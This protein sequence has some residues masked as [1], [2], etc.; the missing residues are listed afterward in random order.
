MSVYE[1]ASHGG[2]DQSETWSTE[3]LPPLA[4]PFASAALFVDP[5]LPAGVGEFFTEH[6]VTTPFAE[7]LS[8]YD[9]ADLEAEAFEA[10]RAEFEDDGFREAL[11]GLADEAAARHLGATGA[12]A[13]AGEAFPAATSE[14][15]HYMEAVAAQADRLLGELEAQ[16]GERPVDAVTAGEIDAVAGFAAHEAGGPLDAQEQFLKKLVGKVKKVVKGVGKLVKKGV[17]AVAKM[18]PLKKLFAFLKK[19][20][21]PLLARVLAKAIGRL[22]QDLQPIARTVAAKFRKKAPGA[23]PVAAPAD[24]AT[25]A[26][27][28]AAAE[29]TE[30][31]AAAPPAEEES[32]WSA[33]AL[34]DEFDARLAEAFLAPTEAAA[35]ELVDHVAA[36]AHRAVGSGPGPLAALDAGRQ[37]LARQL[38]EAEPGRPPLAEMEQFVPLVAASMKLLKL[39][40]K[41]IGRKR[42]VDAIAKPLAILIQGMVGQQAARK[43]SGHVADV[44]LRLLGL[45]AER[46]ADGMLGAEALV[47]TVEDTVREVLSMPAASLQN[48]L[49]LE[50]AVLE[51]FT[52]AAVRHLPA[53]VLRPDLAE[54]ETDGERGIWI[55]CPRAS[56]AHY[57][58]KKYSVVQPVHV[59]R[60]LARAVVFADGETLE[61]RLLEA[62]LPRFPVAAE[63]HFYELMDGAELGQL[64]AFELDG[65]AASYADGARE[66]EQLVPSRPLPIPHPKP[67][68]VVAVGRPGPTPDRRPGTVV[69][70]L[71]VPGLHPRRRPPFAV[72]LDL[73]GH[74]PQLRVLL[75]VGERNAHLLVGHLERQRHVQV[76]TL[77]RGLVGPPVRHALAA[78]VHRMLVRR[79]ITPAEGVPAR[80]TDALADAIGRT[81]A[82]RLPAAAAALAAAAKDPAD[83]VTLTFTFTF[84][85]RA[86]IGRA[87]VGEP[88]LGI[89]SGV[90]H[91]DD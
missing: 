54:S 76:V 63:A 71:K 23:A 41:V 5:G 22:P 47:A 80:L 2:A 85:N 86:A 67:R 6:V 37:Q 9:E 32:P 24:P 27:P 74:R 77:V 61:D 28:A 39:G 29:P 7:A 89:R 68:V 87:D 19:L 88:T 13:Q 12:W 46:T 25:P 59:T 21:R 8:S 17:G 26:D 14:A 34:A 60:P 38:V 16:F 51:A 50:S 58:Y 57:R 62:G 81:V 66:F 33:E 44:G 83:G 69:F 52:D 43:L 56:G 79:G 15:E 30:P 3:S 40:V 4:S 35:T 42:V 55:P 49:L 90:D 65:E 48:E 84:A 72:R 1:M 91:D 53:P 36:E 18:L 64:A 73:S 45:E 10:L 75:R 78:A 82:T 70:R 31:D 11:E 20:V